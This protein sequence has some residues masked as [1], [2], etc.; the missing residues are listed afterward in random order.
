MKPEECKLCETE[1]E[2][3]EYRRLEQNDKAP[4]DFPICYDCLKEL[5]IHLS[6]V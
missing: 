5:K 2:D 4:Y 1:L 6:E 3:L